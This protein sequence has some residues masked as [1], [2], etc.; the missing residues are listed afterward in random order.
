MAK[1]EYED[2]YK[3][4][5]EQAALFAWSAVHGAATLR[6]GRVP[7]ALISIAELAELVALRVIQALKI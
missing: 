1:K 7:G 6:S 3:F 2:D 5:D 4:P